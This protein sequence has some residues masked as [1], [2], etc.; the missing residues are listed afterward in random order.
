MSMDGD[1]A[2]DELRSLYAWL[3]EDPDIRR[4][5]RP[6]FRSAPPRPGRMGADAD[7]I[8]FAVQTGLTLGQVLG[9]YAAWRRTRS[10]PGTVVIER[11]GTKITLSGTDEASLRDAVR[12]LGGEHEGTRTDR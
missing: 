5:A 11:D 12:A 2:D 10:R 6:Q 1:R 7:F 8:Y 4:G 3:T 9:Q